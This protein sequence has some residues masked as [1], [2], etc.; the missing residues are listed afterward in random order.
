M[1]GGVSVG[2]ISDEGAVGGVAVA[3][4]TIG[5]AGRVLSLAL[6]NREHAASG[7][8][9]SNTNS[10]YCLNCDKLITLRF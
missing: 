6:C 5:L 9:N 8:D 4:L 2:S 3:V 7:T 10:Q 1:G